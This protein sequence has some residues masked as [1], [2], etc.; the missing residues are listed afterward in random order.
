L[1]SIEKF[2]VLICSRSIRR[3]S[4]S[5]PVTI[6]ARPCSLAKVIVALVEELETLETS[7]PI[8]KLVSKVSVDSFVILF[9]RSFVTTSP[10]GDLLANDLAEDGLSLMLSLSN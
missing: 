5:V 9:L 2:E 7:R 10:R 6:P 8:P 3:T 1:R 4:S